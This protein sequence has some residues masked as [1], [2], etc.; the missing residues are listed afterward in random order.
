MVKAVHTFLC[1][2]LDIGKELAVGLFIVFFFR[3]R[4]PR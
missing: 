4:W 3:D 1:E 2:E